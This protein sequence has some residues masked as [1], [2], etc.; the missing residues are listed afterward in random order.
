MISA[1]LSRCQ[2]YVLESLDKSH[3]IQLLEQAITRDEILKTKHIY[4]KETDA[5]LRL[6]GGDGRKLLNVFELVINT[7]NSDDISITNE[8]VIASAQENMVLYDKTRTTLRH[9]I[10]LYQVYT[11]K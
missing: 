6:S 3:L 7:Q 10:S 5:L 8:L 1:L 9:N 11:R 4:I 2:V